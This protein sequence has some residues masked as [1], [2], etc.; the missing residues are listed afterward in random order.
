MDEG[1]PFCWLVCHRIYDQ[2]PST[3][4]QT[5]RY[6]KD[7]THAQAFHP[8]KAMSCLACSRLVEYLRKINRAEKKEIVC[9]MRLWAPALSSVLCLVVKAESVITS[10]I[11][12]PISWWWV[13]MRTKQLSMA[14]P[15]G[16]GGVEEVIWLYVCV[17]WSAH[18]AL[19][20]AVYFLPDISTKTF[21]IARMV[22]YNLTTKE[23][24][25]MVKML[26]PVWLSIHLQVKS[27]I[28]KYE[29]PV[30][31]IFLNEFR[32]HLSWTVSRGL[33][34]FVKHFGIHVCSSFKLAPLI[35]IVKLMK[36]YTLLFKKR[37]QTCSHD[38]ST[39]QYQSLSSLR[40]KGTN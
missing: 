14:A 24:N 1:T 10:E 32:R 18:T 26:P 4:F 19:F 28:H 15:G 38:I 7:K 5:P 21:L 37:Q 17:T 20:G 31:C 9:F 34:I 12:P 13:L 22:H 3:H 6:G 39:G 25:Q 2:D 33:R 16:T 35:L 11:F 40:G 8:G 30:E 23:W 36:R 29:P 27:T